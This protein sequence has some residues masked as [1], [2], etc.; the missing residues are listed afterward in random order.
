MTALALGLGA[1]AALG[2]VG[3]GYLRDIDRARDRLQGR[4][5]T[6]PKN[7]DGPA[8]PIIVHPDVRKMLLTARAY[9]EG[10]RALALHTVLLLDLELT[11][12]DHAVRKECADEVA[13]LTPVLKAFFTD[14]A[15]IATSHC[16]RCATR[17][18]PTRGASS[19]SSIFRHSRSSRPS[20][21]SAACAS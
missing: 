14:N 17:S 19:K 1:L 9:A 2:F 21:T 18:S 6:G 8:D 15:W 20:S 5:L 7:P 11:H 4:S 13:L 16:R 10:A 3:A 12:P